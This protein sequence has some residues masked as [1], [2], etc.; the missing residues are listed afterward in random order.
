MPELDELFAKKNK[1]N[2]DYK[3]LLNII[4]DHAYE[5]MVVINAEG[6]ITMMSKGYKEFLG[7]LMPE[8]KHVSDI[9]DN[10]KLPYVVKTGKSEIGE[11]QIIRGQKV[12]ASRIPI[13]KNGKIIG[14]IGKVIFKDITDFYDMSKNIKS[15]ERQINYYKNELDKQRTAKYSFSNI[16]G[17]SD[18]IEEIKKICKR[19][20]MSDSNVLLQGESGTGKELFAHA[21]HNSS[22]RARGP[23]IKVNCG[24]IPS[25]LL[26]SELFGYE[27][28]AFT[29][30]NKKGKPGKFELADNGSIFLDEI[31]DMPF[32]MQ[33]KL[34]RVLQ[35][36]EIERVGGIA[37]K[38]INIRIISATNKDLE[39]EVR[40]G[41]FREDL[42]YRLNVMG[43][44][45]DPL[46]SRK[47]DISPLLDHFLEKLSDQMGVHVKGI[48]DNARSALMDYAWPGNIRELENILE[49]AINLMDSDL[50]IKLVHLPQ[51]L[52]VKKNK[53]S[54]VTKKGFLKEMVEEL[55]KQIITECYLDTGK[56]KKQTAKLLNISRTNLYEKL[57]QYEIK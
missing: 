13:F 41:R 1:E 12:I 9:I 54:E 36:R 38:K 5:W 32:F 20:A 51:Y 56:N 35:E 7:D 15:M 44:F 28:G 40:E 33:G 45:I 18:H 26:E 48:S 16:V 10:T 31:G 6:I 29:G 34:L 19:A 49:R 57:S 55:E 53:K 52:L 25:E 4:I 8:G 47:E 43:V 39:Y 46:R 23:F 14:A 27:G 17:Q 2:I 50:I 24:A 30:A 11:I 42:Y 37:S 22:D 3:E 21:I